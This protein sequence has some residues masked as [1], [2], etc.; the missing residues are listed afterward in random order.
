MILTYTI[1]SIVARPNSFNDLSRSLK[2]LGRAT[3]LVI[4]YVKITKTDPQTI[5][6]MLLEVV[7]LNPI[8]KV[9]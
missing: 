2:L 7:A 9:Q 1:T 3:I 4:V 8:K 6:E 5:T